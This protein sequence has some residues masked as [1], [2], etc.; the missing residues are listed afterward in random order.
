MKTLLQGWW[1]AKRKKRENRFA[2]GKGKLIDAEIFRTRFYRNV[3]ETGKPLNQLTL[4]LLHSFRRAFT[5]SEQMTPLYVSVVY[6]CTMP[7][8]ISVR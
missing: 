8:T 5:R 1:T 7:A 6:V 3:F 2:K 4:P